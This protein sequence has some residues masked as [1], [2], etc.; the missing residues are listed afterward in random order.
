MW[1]IIDYK[2][3]SFRLFGLFL[4]FCCS[5]ISF[6]ASDSALQALTACMLFYLVLDNYG[7]FIISEL[8]AHRLKSV[9]NNFERS[10]RDHPGETVH[11]FWSRM[12]MEAEEENR[13]LLE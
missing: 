6:A 8:R 11:L 9:I 12:R 4:C 3:H 7:L 5:A 10:K 2:E 13:R 1:K